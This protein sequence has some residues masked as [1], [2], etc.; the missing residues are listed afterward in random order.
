MCNLL[1]LISSRVDNLKLKQPATPMENEEKQRVLLG[2]LKFCVHPQHQHQSARSSL[3]LSASASRSVSVAE[4]KHK[5][6][7]KTA[8]AA[9][10]AASDHP[11]PHGDALLSVVLS[12]SAPPSQTQSS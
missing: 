9:A 7:A 5:Y 2:L 1:L 10:S 11:R 12:Q 8:R 6:E 4:T 3:S